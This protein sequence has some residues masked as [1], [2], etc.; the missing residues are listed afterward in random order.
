FLFTVICFQFGF[1][2]TGSIKGQLYD[3]IENKGFGY[4][5]VIINELHKGTQAD[6]NG[7][8]RIENIPIGKYS[9]KISYIGNLDEEI[10]AVEIFKDSTTTL[11]ITYPPFCKYYNSNKECPVCRKEDKVIPIVYGMPT[12][13]MGRKAEKG[14][15]IIAGCE[16][17]GCDPNWDCKRDKIEF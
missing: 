17:T 15:L 12:N 4:A 2:Q 13:K 16:I 7:N 1:S 11:N 6:Q 14:K 3:T 9:M 10:K 8:F 5:Y